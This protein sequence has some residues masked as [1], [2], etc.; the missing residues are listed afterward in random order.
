[1][2]RARRGF[3]LAILVAVAFLTVAALTGGGLWALGFLM[4]LGA[5]VLIT[6]IAAAYTRPMFRRAAAADALFVHQA[7]I[8]LG[9]VSIEPLETPPLRPWRV[10]PDWTYEVRGAD[11]TLIAKCERSETADAIA[12]IEANPR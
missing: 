11:G 1:M 6:G 5:G 2:T 12:S 8:L 10:E 3:V 7:V 9:V 4:G